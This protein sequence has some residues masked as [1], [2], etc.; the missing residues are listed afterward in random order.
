METLSTNFLIK[1]SPAAVSIVDTKMRFI[2]H[3]EVWLKTFN[4]KERNIEGKSFYDVLPNTP[5]ELRQI[6]QKALQGQADS[7]NGTKFISEEGQLRWLKWKINPWK[8]ESGAIGGLIMVMEDITEQKRKEELLI[9]AKSVARIGG[10][11][12]DLVTNTIY[13]TDMT[14]RIHEV[15][16]DFVPT[17]E[18]GIN[19]YKPGEHRE[20]I[21]QLVSEGMS[22]G[23]PWDAELQIITAKGREIWVRAKGEA[24]IV[25]GKC[26]RL[27]GTFQDIDEK[28]KA[29]LKYQ[30][31]SDRLAIATN[32]SEIGIW[33]YDLVNNN[34]VWDDHMYRIYGVDKNAFTGVVEAWE[35]CVH[36]EDKERCNEELEMA[37]RGEKEFKTEFRVLWPGEE[38]RYIRAES[39]VKRDE[40]GNPIRMIGTNWDI[41]KEKLAEKKLKDLLDISSEQNK[42]LLNFAHIV[43]HNLRS[44][45]SNLSMLS[46]FLSKEEDEHEKLHLLNM[47]ED[48]TE[49]LN[50]TVK[51][52]NEVVKLKTGASEKLKPVNLYKTIKTVEKNLGVMLKDQGVKCIIDVSKDILVKAIPAYLDSIFLNLFTNSLKYSSED[53]KPALEIRS[54]LKGDRVEV[55]VTDNGLG[56]DLERHGNQIFGMYKTF[57][58][59]PDAKGIGLFITKNQVESMNG[60][61][62]VRS[63]VGV[64]TTFLLEF[65]STK[66]NQNE[67]N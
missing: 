15:D 45:S 64:G 62:Q 50:E 59:H 41:T 22:D 44:H 7:S 9:K 36:P 40:Y 8:K 46:G 39:V 12:C 5:P 49:S 60:R 48:A 53:R 51:H 29:E 25:N 21:T 20:K 19:F 33:D 52:L 32:A 37:L 42:S 3:S 10:W 55:S 47:L 17:L 65:E 18:S 27:Y 34:L 1:D 6:H 35:S 54:E 57:H 16:M 38:V 30:E 56:I 43:S 31:L 58:K 61:I 23:K 11:E 24:E 4:I 63:E 26:L 2:S 66:T 13:W 67:Y 28:K 14:K